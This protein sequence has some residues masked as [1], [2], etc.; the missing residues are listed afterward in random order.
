MTPL[1]GED[2][3]LKVALCRRLPAIISLQPHL[4]QR[5]DLQLLAYTSLYCFTQFS[6]DHTRAAP[7]CFGSHVYSP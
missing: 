6:L 1:L 4:S 5:S 7:T 2:K 3:M